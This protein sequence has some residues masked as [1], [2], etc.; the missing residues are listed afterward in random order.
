MPDID[1]NG[2]A[3]ASYIDVAFADDYLAGDLARA[4]DWEVLEEITKSRAVVSA[5]RLLQRLKWKAGPPAVETATLPVKEAAAILAAN[6]AAKPA[7]GDSA[8]TGSNVKSVGAG[9]AKVEFFMPQE[10]ALLPDN[11]M[12]LLR[13]L[14]GED[15]SLL[16]GFDAVAFGSHD[17]QRSRFDPDDWR[18]VGT[19]D[20]LDEVRE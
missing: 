12:A 9:S 2:K 14:L 17:N 7:S 20:Y 16:F 15:D 18:L 19:G 3:Y 4:E 8:A 10:G 1:I 5:T 6:I 13:D 11:V